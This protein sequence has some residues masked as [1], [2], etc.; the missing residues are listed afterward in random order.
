M[1]EYVDYYEELTPDDLISEEFAKILKVKYEPTEKKVGTAAKGGS[2]EVIGKSEPIKIFIENIPHPVTII[3]LIVKDLSHPVNVGRNF[4]GRT[5][6]KLEFNTEAGYLELKGNKT[7]LISKGTSMDDESVTDHRIRKVL[8]NPPRPDYRKA[9]MVY[10]SGI[11]Y[12]KETGRRT[13]G[14]FPKEE[15]EIPAHSAKFV[16]VTTRGEFTLG[17]VYQKTLVIEQVEKENEECVAL[18]LPG[19]CQLTEG[20]VYCLV[21]NPDMQRIRIPSHTELG[22]MTILEGEEVSGH[23]GEPVYNT[24]KVDQLI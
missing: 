9:E 6:G 21:V 18:L 3:P 2:V 5:E 12:C 11:Y 22:S 23:M 14:I 10:E 4:L 17:D 13:A 8:E 16:P 7:R 1:F 20:E 24:E 19:V 15:I